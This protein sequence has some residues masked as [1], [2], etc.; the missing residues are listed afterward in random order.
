MKIKLLKLQVVQRVT[1]LLAAVKGKCFGEEAQFETS[2]NVKMK[3]NNGM[4]RKVQLSITI[5]L[6]QKCIL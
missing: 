2:T 6:T 1:I 3:N 5:Q 4:Q